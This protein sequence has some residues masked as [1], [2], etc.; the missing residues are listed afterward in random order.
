MES[1]LSTITFT[2]EQTQAKGN[3]MQGYQIRR[4][5]R[6]R[7]CDHVRGSWITFFSVKP[8]PIWPL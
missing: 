2:H 8:A 1:R 5:D 3:M 7:E 6:D 4:H